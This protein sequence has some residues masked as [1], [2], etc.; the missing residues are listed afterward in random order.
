[1]RTKENGNGTINAIAVEFGIDRIALKKF[2]QKMQEQKA[3]KETPPKEPDKA[4]QEL[5]K[6]RGPS[7]ETLLIKE[8][9]LQAIASGKR[10]SQDISTSLPGVTP[11]QVFAALRALELENRIVKIGVILREGSRGK[12][13]AV[14]SIE[15]RGKTTA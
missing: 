13:P 10:T 7:K 5:R 11:P 6:G 3:S 12:K 4:Q 9:V 2:L 15:R 14:W 8:Q 1:M